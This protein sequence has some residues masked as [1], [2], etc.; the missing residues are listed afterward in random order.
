MLL[1][2]T[3]QIT[4]KSRK[5]F[6]GITKQHFFG[7]RPVKVTAKYN[8]IIKSGQSRSYPRDPYIISNRKVPD[9]NAFNRK[10]C[11]LNRGVQFSDVSTLKP[12]SDCRAEFADRLQMHV[13]VVGNEL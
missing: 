2:S 10:A 5:L 7:D 4:S 9:A 11:S 6:G 13:L 1:L 3:F 8:D 12:L